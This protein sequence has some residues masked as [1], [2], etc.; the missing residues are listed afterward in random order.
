MYSISLPTSYGPAAY[1]FSLSPNGKVSQVKCLSLELPVAV[2][3]LTYPHAHPED[4]QQHLEAWLPIVPYL[5]ELGIWLP[6]P[7]EYLVGIQQSFR[8]QSSDYARMREAVLNADLLEDDQD[9]RH[10]QR[11]SAWMKMGVYRKVVR[12]PIINNRQ[13]TVFAAEKLSLPYRRLAVNWLLDT[14]P[15]APP[16]RI[17]EWIIAIG[18][19]R[20]IDHER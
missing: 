4:L 11:V 7:P 20:H 18:K 15:L 14:F 2:L 5:V 13:E 10:W 9:H 1:Q 8:E 12:F 17:D 16:I 3:K 6:E 19:T